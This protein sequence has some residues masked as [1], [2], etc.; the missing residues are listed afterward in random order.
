MNGSTEQGREG[1]TRE[2]GKE[3]NGVVFLGYSAPERG[4]RWGPGATGWVV[5]MIGELCVFMCVLM[6]VCAC[7]RVRKRKEFR[8]LSIQLWE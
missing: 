4:E 1:G 5:S 6:A 7:K 8:M 2:G 3:V